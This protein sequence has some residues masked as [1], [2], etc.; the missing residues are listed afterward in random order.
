LPYNP[1]KEVDKEAYIELNDK[2]KLKEQKANK[3][4]T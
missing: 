1:Y 4:E 2:E 3:K